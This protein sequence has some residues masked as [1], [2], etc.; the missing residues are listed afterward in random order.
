MINLDKHGNPLRP[1]IVWLD[2]RQAQAAPEDQVVVG[3]LHSS[4]RG[5]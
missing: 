4:W 2:Q 1:A 5:G 3:A